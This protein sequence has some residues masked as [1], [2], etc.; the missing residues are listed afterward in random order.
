MVSRFGAR[1]SLCVKQTST[2][3]HSLLG[4]GNRDMASLSR[5]TLPARAELY[6]LPDDTAFLGGGLVSRSGRQFNWIKK[7]KLAQMDYS[8]GHA[9]KHVECLYYQLWDTL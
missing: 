8:E 1:L 6:V 2:T 4:G 5:A 3:A 9:N 7:V